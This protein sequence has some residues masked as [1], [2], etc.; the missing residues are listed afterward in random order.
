MLDRSLSHATSTSKV[1]EGCSSDEAPLAGRLFAPA[2]KCIF[3]YS[4]VHRLGG[5]V[6][7]EGSRCGMVCANA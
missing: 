1:A 6:A 4:S 5:L 3:S 7:L 2:S